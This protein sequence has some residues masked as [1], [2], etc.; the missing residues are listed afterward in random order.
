MTDA[1]KLSKLGLAALAYARL[2]WP[3]FTLQPRSKKPMGLCNAGE[4]DQTCNARLPPKDKVSG[5]T[6]CKTCGTVHTEAGGLY[7]AT[8]DEATITRWWT[9]EPKANVGIRCGAGILVVDIDIPNP[10]EDK[11]EDGEAT[12]ALLEAENDE[13]PKTPNQRTGEI[14]QA[15]GTMRRGR[16]YVFKV[17]GEVRNTARKLGPGIDTRG[18]GGYIVA[19]P[20]LHP[21]GVNYE[22]EAD[23]KPSKV[24]LAPAPA[25]LLALLAETKKLSEVARPMPPATRPADTGDSENRWVNKALDGEYQRA[26]DPSKGSRNNRLNTAGFKLGQLVGGNVLDERTARSTL[27]AAAEASG[28]AADEGPDAV[29]KVIQ[30]SLSAG[31]AAPRSVPERQPQQGRAE[32]RVVSDNTKR[33][34]EPEPAPVRKTATGNTGWLEGW[35]D[36]VIFKPET[37]MLAPKVLQ[38]GVTLLRFR[39]EFVGL[40]RFNERTQCIMVMRKPPWTANG[41]PYPRPIT[42]SDITGFRTEIEKLEM[43]L[44]KNDC[45]DAI[46]R[47]AEELGFDPVKDALNSFTWDGVERLDHWLVEYLGAADNSFTRQAGSKWLIGAV[48]R[49]LQPGTKFDYMLVLEGKQGIMKSQAL[50]ALAEALGPDTFMDRLSPLQTKDSMIELAGKVIVEVAEMSG[51]RGA[52]AEAIK[53]FLSAQDDTLRMPW[54]R[55][56]TR[57]KRGCVFAGTLNPDGAGWTDDATGGRRF[58]PVEVSEVNLDGLKQ[59]APQ[60]WAEARARYDA[61]E[62]TWLADDVVLEMAHEEVMRRTSEDAWAAIIDEFIG[63]KK[64]VSTD[65]ILSELG[66][67]VDRRTNTESARVSRHMTKRGWVVQFPKIAGKTVR[68]WGRP[69]DAGKVDLFDEDTDG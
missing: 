55:N 25:W 41:V 40:F 68:Q 15:D 45:A 54:D 52:Q 43:R 4:G 16:Q 35:D 44:G 17:D 48:S 47:A 53:R 34:P 20:S 18:D 5:E 24:P 39:K 61:G 3:V 59:D 22:W 2:G 37:R 9:K 23:A 51:I 57:L 42:D 38:N 8:T 30:S 49:I 26:A 7:A 65:Q 29:A 11:Q 50:R 6:T 46:K 19:A 12:L 1:P 56:P 32:L 36:E 60:L 28:W 14:K 64:R 27:E 58:W 67:A 31:M 62:Q 33:D 69:R 13:L 63:D 21:S 10:E 66:V